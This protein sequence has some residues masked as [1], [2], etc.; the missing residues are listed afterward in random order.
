MYNVY[1]I[2]NHSGE[3]PPNPP[4]ALFADSITHN[5]A[6]IQ[7]TVIS[8]AYGPEM[9]VVMYGTNMNTLDQTSSMTATSGN[10]INRVNFMLSVGLTGLEMMTT[11][12]YRVVAMNGD[13][14]ITP[15]DIIASFNTSG[16]G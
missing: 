14:R 2:L 7:W 5:S 9:Y 13:D 10:D 8:I 4:R 16:L 11:Y 6:T 1:K 15:S 3:A 12:Y